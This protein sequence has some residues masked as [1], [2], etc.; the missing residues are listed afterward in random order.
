MCH[1]TATAVYACS[2]AH[3]WRWRVIVKRLINYLALHISIWVVILGRYSSDEPCGTAAGHPCPSFP[4]HSSHIFP[5]LSLAP[6]PALTHVAAAAGGSV[7]VVAL[8]NVDGQA[9]WT[10]GWVRRSDQDWDQNK[11]SNNDLKY[12]FGVALNWQPKRL[13][14]SSKASPLYTTI[15][16]VELRTNLWRHRSKL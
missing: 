2:Q 7:E 14:Q 9:L 11:H 12:V 4:S 16:H 10:T 8:T 5:A 13:V 15:Q 3:T 1:L 6:P